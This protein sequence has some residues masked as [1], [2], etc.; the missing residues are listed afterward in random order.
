M[1]YNCTT[2]TNSVYICIYI[3][4]FIK[5]YTYKPHT[6]IPLQVSVS[7]W[8]ISQLICPKFVKFN[9]YSNGD[10]AKKQKKNFYWSYNK[11]DLWVIFIPAT[12]QMF[13][14]SQDGVWPSSST[15]SMFQVS[16]PVYR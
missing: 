12:P 13:W 3:K 7:S 16:G 9:L 11:K 2:G 1:I 4:Q 5:K 10:V 8:L 14:P 15:F 6:K